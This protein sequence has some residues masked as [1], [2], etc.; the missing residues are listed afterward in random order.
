MTRT[1][2]SR[3]SNGYVT[4]GEFT[5][6]RVTDRAIAIDMEDTEWTWLPRSVVEEGEDMEEF[7]R[8]GINVRAWF[9]KKE[10]LDAT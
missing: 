7:E 10:G 9:A 4:L 2:R 3:A 6:M 8:Y 1:Q 5:V